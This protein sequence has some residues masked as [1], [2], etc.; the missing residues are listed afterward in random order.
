MTI[1][2]YSPQV[3]S[4]FGAN[5]KTTNDEHEA[6]QMDY[7][8][9]LLSQIA[10]FM[11]SGNA[12]MDIQQMLDKF[13]TEM[14][15]KPIPLDLMEKQLNQMIDEVNGAKIAV[16]FPHWSLSDDQSRPGYSFMHFVLSFAQF[17]DGESN[18]DPKIHGWVEKI[19][20]YLNTGPWNP[21][22]VTQM[23]SQFFNAANSLGPNPNG[24][25]FP[26]QQLPPNIFS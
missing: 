2:P 20:S 18:Q 17:L 16:P 22:S 4:P 9:N 10:N 14:Q 6:Q 15:Q 5:P 21:E 11:G 25:I 7:I 1:N 12:Y 19:A 24:C 3:S 26:S 8:L 13:S 23:I